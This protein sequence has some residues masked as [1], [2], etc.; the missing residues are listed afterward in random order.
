MVY[1]GGYLELFIEIY[2][3]GAAFII[4]FLILQIMV[5]MRQVDKKLLNARLFL[6]EDIWNKTWLYI[7]IAGAAFALHSVIGIIRIIMGFYIPLLYEITQIL[8]TL[9]FIV[10]VYQWYLF[11]GE[12]KSRFLPV[13]QK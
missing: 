13:E 3:M 10:M 1:V 7:S 4:V 6:K 11:I 2:N 5:M 8:F 9:S 12:L